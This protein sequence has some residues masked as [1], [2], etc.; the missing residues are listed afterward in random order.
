MNEYVPD[1]LLAIV[2]IC[3]AM[4]AIAALARK[5]P[6]SWFGQWVGWVFRRIIGEPIATWTDRHFRES[7]MPIIEEALDPIN[8]QLVHTHDCLERVGTE[9][10]EHAQVA[11][12]A[13]QEAKV[14]VDANSLKMDEHIISDAGAFAE[15]KEWRD[16][17]DIDLRNIQQATANEGGT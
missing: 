11:A 10:V 6:L 4:T 3:T 16:K 14:A 7:V 5:P 2:G 13:A 17:V 12:V 15:I 9:A 1:W 8:A